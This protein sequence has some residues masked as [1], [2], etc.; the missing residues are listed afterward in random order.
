VLT[1]ADLISAYLF[2]GCCFFL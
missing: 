1:T 2:Q